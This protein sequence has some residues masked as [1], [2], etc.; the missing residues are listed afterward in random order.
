[1]AHVVT[2]R[3]IQE[4]TLKPQSL[5]VATSLGAL[6][7]TEVYLDG[8]FNDG[9]GSPRSFIASVH[10][11]MAGKLAI[12]FS[13][14]G[15][16]ITVCEGQNSFAS[17]LKTGLLLT[18]DNN[19]ILLIVI[20]EKVELFTRIQPYLSEDCKKFNSVNWEEAAVAFL[21]NV[22]SEPEKPYL[23]STCSQPL[24]NRQSPESK[25]NGLILKNNMKDI[26]ALPLME[27]SDSFSKAAVSVFNLINSSQTGTFTIGTYS[28]SA[29]AVSVVTICM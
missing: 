20:D 4:S 1:M 27:T 3:I 28:P 6:N 9:F 11:S 26:S 18:G 8:V 24:Q 23:V 7:E 12:D 2:E 29:Q 21:L 25:Y 10:N 13:I 19:P 15:P 16:N 5:I 17:A 22:S 14:K